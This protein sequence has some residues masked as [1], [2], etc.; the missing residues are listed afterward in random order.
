MN[1]IEGHPYY[2]GKQL[3]PALEAKRFYLEE[4][5]YVQYFLKDDEAGHLEI[6]I[7]LIHEHQIHWSYYFPKKPFFIRSIACSYENGPDWIIKLLDT[8]N[9]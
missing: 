8:I 5:D 1:E 2:I 7:P 9:N 3:F 4:I 6:F